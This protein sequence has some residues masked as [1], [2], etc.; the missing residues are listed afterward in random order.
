MPGQTG[1]LPVLAPTEGQSPRGIARNAGSRPRRTSCFVLITAVWRRARRGLTFPPIWA[2]C[3]AVT[4][5]P[6]QLLSM[7][8]RLPDFSLSLPAGATGFPRLA[9]TSTLQKQ[10]RAYIVAME[11]KLAYSTVILVISALSTE[12]THTHTHLLHAN[13]QFQGFEASM[14]TSNEIFS[15]HKPCLSLRQAETVSGEPG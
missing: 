10:L 9:R 3:S 7:P 8:W 11:E 15:S 4:L 1:H 2:V 13:I 12:H 5:A 14:R 6:G